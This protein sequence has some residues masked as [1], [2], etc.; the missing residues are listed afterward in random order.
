MPG[1]LAGL[2]LFLFF[3]SVIS[4][5]AEAIGA[6]GYGKSYGDLS[7]A[8]WQWARS[9][10]ADIV[11]PDG[12]SPGHPLAAQGDMDCSLNQSNGPIWFLGGSMFDGMAMIRNCVVPARKALFFPL[13]NGV[14]LNRESDNMTV[15]EKQEE[16]HF[17]GSLACRM[18][19]MLDNTPTVY[20]LPTVRAQSE[21]FLLEVATPDVFGD[22]GVVDPEAV[23]DGYWVMVPPLSKGE[24]VLHFTGSLCHPETGDPFFTSD[25]TYN[26]SVE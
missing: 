17:F 23:A 8:W 20:S 1:L 2:V 19:S 21:P 4:V 22:D 11:A 7:A 3:A 25:V 14:T 12:V 16:A 26:L 6:K 9:I 24:H 15:D 5:G 10:P 13:V 18:D